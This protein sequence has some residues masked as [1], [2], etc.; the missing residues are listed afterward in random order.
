MIHTANK[1]NNIAFND[2]FID[3]DSI[4]IRAANKAINHLIIQC[5]TP[6]WIN[7]KHKLNHLL[8]LSNDEKI[9]AANKALSNG[10]LDEYIN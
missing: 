2:C 6:L 4:A 1:T 8:T 5:G 10:E 9:N 3:G 7:V